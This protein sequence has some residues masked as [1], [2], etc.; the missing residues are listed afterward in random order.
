MF[1]QDP[2]VV[3]EQSVVKGLEHLVAAL[4]VAVAHR[5]SCR[6]LSQS[7]VRY[8]GL[9]DADPCGYVAKSETLVQ[10]SESQGDELVI[11]LISTASL[12]GFMLVDATG[13]HPAGNEV[14]DLAD[15][16]LVRIFGTPEES[17][18]KYF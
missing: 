6:A 13:E 8:E 2:P 16:R 17:H 1:G 7:Q 10:L 15:K 3:G 18:I 12:I 5:G 11:G 9:T 4:F 14:D